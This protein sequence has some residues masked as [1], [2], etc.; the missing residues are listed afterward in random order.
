MLSVFRIFTGTFL[1]L[2]LWLLI[3]FVVFILG[4]YIFSPSSGSDTSTVLP[5]GALML[6][7]GWTFAYA[8]YI[9]LFALGHCIFLEIYIKARLFIRPAIASLLLGIIFGALQWLFIM[10]FLWIGARLYIGIPFF[11]T[12]ACTGYLI[13]IIYYKFLFE[14]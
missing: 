11:I 8:P 6:F 1:Y 7:G 10:L 14:F 4:G 2:S 5:V 3:S 9:L 13:G 12:T